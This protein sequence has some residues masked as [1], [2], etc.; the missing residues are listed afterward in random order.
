M[1]FLP[2]KRAWPAF[3]ALALFALLASG[4]CLAQTTGKNPP[5]DR[6]SVSPDW[7]GAGPL[8]DR[9]EALDLAWN[10]PALSADAVIDRL[11]AASE[12]RAA[13]LRGYR[14]TRLYHLE[15]RGLFGAREA[16]MQVLASYRAPQERS[17]SIISETGSKLLLSRVLLK[18][19][20]SEREAFRNERQIELSPANYRF[21]SLGMERSPGCDPCYLLEVQPR[22]DNKFLYRGKIWIDA[23]DFALV[24]MEGQPVKSPSFWIKDTEILSNWERVGDFWL[25]QHSR[26]VSHIRMG[27]T[28]LLTVDYRDYQITGMGKTEAPALGPQLPAPASLT[29]ER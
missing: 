10:P 11:M 5:P 1:S 6:A 21:R 29:P 26:S 4:N 27:G 17:F 8:A 15:Y 9:L 20:D 2:C 13:E 24:R 23:N 7:S 12:R 22:Q 3:S 18:L 16:T 25:I 19:L 14:G 28:A